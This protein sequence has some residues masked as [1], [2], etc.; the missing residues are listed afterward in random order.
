MGGT[1]RS[2]GLIRRAAMP[3]LALLVVG[4]FAA[5]AI[6]GPNGLLAWGGYRQD[7]NERRAELARL[8]AEREQ[9]RHRSA[10]LDPR[11]ADPDMADEL[12]RRDLGLVRPDEVIITLE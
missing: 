7:L 5:H 11:K 6:A 12:V 8:E 4:T 10:L 2:L 1:R 9:L 3:A